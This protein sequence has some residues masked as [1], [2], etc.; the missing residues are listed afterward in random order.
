[1]DS[2]P[3]YKNSNNLLLFL[4]TTCGAPLS[5]ITNLNLLC[6][7]SLQMKFK[8]M[9]KTDAPYVYTIIVCLYLPYASKTKLHFSVE[10]FDHK[11]GLSGCS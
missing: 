8:T 11:N 2:S 7:S 9:S 10:D 3:L 5:M 1:M 6:F 4:D